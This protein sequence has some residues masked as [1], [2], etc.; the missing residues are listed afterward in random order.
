MHRYSSLFLFAVSGL[1]FI[2]LTACD[3]TAPEGGT[4]DVRLSSTSN[5]SNLSK[6][7][8]TVEHVSIASNYDGSN[9][10]RFG[11]W[12]NML[13]EGVEVDLTELEGPTDMRLARGQVLPGDFDGLHVRFSETAEIRYQSQ[14]G[15][16]VQTTA[17]L[18]SAS[19][20][21]VALTFDSLLLDSK[22][23]SATLSLQFD[24]DGSFDR[25]QNKKTFRFRPS[26][27]VGELI[28]N[29]DARTVSQ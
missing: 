26:I 15:K 10:E 20:R 16:S 17:T 1:L 4:L 8:V 23:E 29:G 11:D 24:L 21:N 27:T 13:Q 6:A 18:S 9:P 25:Q 14:N 5:D 12:P 7:V 2:T 3:Y 28:V 19:H 22:S